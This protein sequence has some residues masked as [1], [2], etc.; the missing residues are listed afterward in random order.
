MRLTLASPQALA[1][2]DTVYSDVPHL[3][4]PPSSQ[5]NMSLQRSDTVRLRS[6]TLSALSVTLMKQ[7]PAPT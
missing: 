1:W 5:I 4:L 6:I 3:I 2:V 7:S